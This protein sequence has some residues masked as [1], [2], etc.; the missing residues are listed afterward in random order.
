MK[1][2]KLTV[3][4]ARSRFHAHNI[5]ARIAE[6]RDDGHKINTVES[7]KNGKTVYHYSMANSRKA[8]KSK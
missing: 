1:G 2:D 7:N 5:S 8:A 4:Q 6:L 3:K